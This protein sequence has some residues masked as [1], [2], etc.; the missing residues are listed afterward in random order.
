MKYFAEKSAD[1][2]LGVP[3]KVTIFFIFQD[4]FFFLSISGYCVLKK[5]FCIELTGQTISFMNLIS[6]SLPRFVKFSA[7]SLNQFIY[8][9][10][11]LIT[12]QYC[13]GFWHTLT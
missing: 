2:L 11:R 3:L 5:S 8:F 4:F 1:S 13:G 7:S 9:N 6:K 12:L 10:W